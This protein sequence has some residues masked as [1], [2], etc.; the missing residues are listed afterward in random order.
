MTAQNGPPHPTRTRDQP[1]EAE[2]MLAERVRESAV[3]GTVQHMHSQEWFNFASDGYL[4]TDLEGVIHEANFAAAA[5]VGCAQGISSGQAA[6]V[7][8]WR[9]KAPQ[10]FTSMARLRRCTSVGRW[11]TQVSV[12]T[13][14]RAR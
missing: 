13:A 10:H 8:S 12:W 3:A 11:E 9:R 2:R 6:R 1:E 4:L 14:N 7:C 5:P